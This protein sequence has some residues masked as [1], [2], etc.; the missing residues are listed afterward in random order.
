MLDAGAEW[1]CYASD[2]TRTFPIS[3]TFS[4]EA[5]AIYRAVARM[6]AECIE[7]VRPGFL[8][9]S[10]HLHAC[11]VAVAELL[12]LGILHNGSAAE[13]LARGTVAAFFPHGL[14]HHVGLEVHDV[15]GRERLLMASPLPSSARGKA[16][17][18]RE[19]MR[20]EQAAEIYKDAVD[21]MQAIAKG[22]AGQ[23][24]SGG[25]QKLEKNMVVTIEPGM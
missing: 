17:G 20:P 4:K 19:W 3:G 25:R 9:H 13:I 10:L 7:R 1:K 22:A 8:F 18:K 14:G 5:A 11:A 6:Q 16:P 12:A 23:V 15:P 2:V 21:M 24:L